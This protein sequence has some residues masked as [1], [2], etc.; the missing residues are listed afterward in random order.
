LEITWLGQSCFRLHGRNV[1]LLTDP[2]APASGY[3]LGKVS[4]DV[5]T[6]SNTH[7]NHASVEDVGGSPV[8]LDGPGEYEVHGIV[9]TGFRTNP[10]NDTTGVRNTAFIYEIDDVTVCHLGDVA[11]VL[12]TE[13]IELAKE[14]NVLLVPV[15]G[16]CTIGAAQAA[17]VIAQIEPKVIVPMHYSTENSTAELESIEHF[18]R[19][20]GLTTAEPQAKLVITQ[21]SL[22]LEPTVSVLQYKA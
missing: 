18:L 19:E 9:I 2:F 17:Q 20:M 6:V 8:V 14:V 4:A 15:G 22:P 7:P 10:R 13:Q 21:S 1:N 11:N 5:V 12:G 16:N 3:T